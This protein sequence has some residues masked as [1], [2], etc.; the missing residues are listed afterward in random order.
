MRATQQRRLKA[1]IDEKAR[2]L[3][4]TPFG[5]ARSADGL[6]PEIKRNRRSERK[7]AYD[8]FL[9]AQIKE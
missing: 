4:R 7:S 9:E 2:D 8:R 5:G 6:S 1:L 3:R